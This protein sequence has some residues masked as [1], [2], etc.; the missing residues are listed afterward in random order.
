MARLESQEW[1]ALA[2]NSTALVQHENRRWFTLARESSGLFWQ[3]NVQWRE[4]A[5]EFKADL[6][7]QMWRIKVFLAAAAAVAIVAVPF[8]QAFFHS[9]F[10]GN[11]TVFWHAWVTA[12]HW[13]SCLACVAVAN[14]ATLREMLVSIVVLYGAWLLDTRCV[15][16]TVEYSVVMAFVTLSVGITSVV[17][18]NVSPASLLGREDEVGFLPIRVLIAAGV[19][20]CASFAMYELLV[21]LLQ[22]LLLLSLFCVF[23]LPFLVVGGLLRLSAESHFYPHICTFFK[24]FCVR[25]YVLFSLLL[26]YRRRSAVE[27]RE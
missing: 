17:F 12:R 4:L 8:F 11:S 9:E 7:L 18:R 1:R 10:A 27:R 19:G 2:R 13:A 20:A 15:F 21:R 3:E 26:R 6:L 22:R 25:F 23:G 5:R 16:P 14:A 24:H